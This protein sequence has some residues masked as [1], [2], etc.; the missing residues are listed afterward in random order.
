MDRNHDRRKF[1]VRSAVGAGVIWSAPVVTTVG[2]YPAAAASGTPKV[3]TATRPLPGT[4]WTNELCLG[5]TP[6]DH[7]CTTLTAEN[8]EPFAEML[9]LNSDP[10]TNQSWNTLDYAVYFLQFNG[11]IGLRV[12]ENGVFR[13][14]FGNILV[15]D[16]V[17]ITRSPSGV[18]TY[19]LNGTDFFTSTV[20]SMAPLFLDSSF[21]SQPTGFWSMGSTTHSVV[22]C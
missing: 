8:G 20:N 12:Y 22:V 2:L 15:G 7:L 1:L 13:G 6:I 5:S 14:F 18:V 17:C 16:E 9:G 4:G 21:W 11:T 3:T 19:S 10:A